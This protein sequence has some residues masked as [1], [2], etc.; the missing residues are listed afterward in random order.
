[1]PLDLSWSCE[2]G[3]QLLRW[4]ITETREDLSQMY[5]QIW[6]DAADPNTAETGSVHK[7]AAR[8]TIGTAFPN[9]QLQFSEHGKPTLSPN[10]AH[11]NHS[12]AGDYALF[13]HHPS[14]SVGVDIEQIR[15]QLARIYPRFC[16]AN[17]M[18]WLGESPSL[19]DLLLMWCAKEALYKAIGQKGTDFREHLEISQFKTPERST[20]KGEF[21]ERASHQINQEPKDTPLQTMNEAQK[22]TDEALTPTGKMTAQIH[23]EGWAQ[24]CELQFVIWEKYTAVWV[25]L[26]QL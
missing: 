23:L 18:A 4:H 19:Q 8:N 13:I 3:A 26:P 1:M 20:N 14:L 12:H 10:S 24:T 25:A 22:P 7:L 6:G 15:T 9:H 16:N 17:E 11:I 5:N 21:S 2:S